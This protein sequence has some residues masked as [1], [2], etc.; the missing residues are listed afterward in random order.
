MS[1]ELAEWAAK[2]ADTAPPLADGQID[3]LLRIFRP[4]PVDSHIDQPAAA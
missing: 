4:E 2:L 1:P 3:V